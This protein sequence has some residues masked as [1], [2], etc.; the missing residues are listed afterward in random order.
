MV[1]ECLGHW[2]PNSV[3]LAP[4]KPPRTQAEA[5]QPLLVLAWSELRSQPGAET[6]S[7]EGPDG[8]VRKWGAYTPP[9]GGP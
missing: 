6:H 5:T 7:R 3:T 1:S 9:S 4:L 2:L 8:W